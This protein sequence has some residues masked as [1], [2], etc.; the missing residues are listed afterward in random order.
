[1]GAA[2]NGGRGDAEGAIARLGGILARNVTFSNPTTEELHFVQEDSPD[3]IGR[4]IANEFDGPLLLSP[5]CVL[6]RATKDSELRNVRSLR[7]FENGADIATP[8]S[9]VRALIIRAQEDWAI[10]RECWR[11][12]RVFSLNVEP[13]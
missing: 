8:D 5:V 10:A 4:A 6:K 9:A 2:S 11:L 13:R 7:S 1:L 12:M 3:E